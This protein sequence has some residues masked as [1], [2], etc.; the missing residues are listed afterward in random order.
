MGQDEFDTPGETAQKRVCQPPSYP[1]SPQ[2][3]IGN[4]NT[5]SHTQEETPGKIGYIN[6]V[7]VDG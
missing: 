5:I 6:R 7:M 3:N 2:Y 1:T 4:V